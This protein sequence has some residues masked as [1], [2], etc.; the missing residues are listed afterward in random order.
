MTQEKA[1]PQN[2]TVLFIDDEEL[3][4]DVAS[5]MFED[6]GW[7]SILATGG[8]N[9]VDLYKEFQDEID[10]SIIDFSMPEMNGIETAQAIRNLNEKAKII[11]ISGLVSDDDLSDLADG[12]HKVAFL[13]K[14]FHFEDLVDCVSE[15]I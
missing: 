8:K 3:M 4:R 7:K 13:A 15:T 6:V 2:L 11:M 12:E 10:V 14:P 1:T 5:M 9:G